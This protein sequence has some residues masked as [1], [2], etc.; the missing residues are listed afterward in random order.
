MIVCGTCDMGINFFFCRTQ[1]FSYPTPLGGVTPKK[2]YPTR[3]QNFFSS[4]PPD[5]EVARMYTEPKLVHPVDTCFSG[6]GTPH[7]ACR[8]CKVLH[9][10]LCVS[11]E[12]RHQIQLGRLQASQEWLPEMNQRVRSQK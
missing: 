7:I 3:Y 5:W 6:D 10:T 4:P 8:E 11:V 1:F 9:Y 12:P 2:K